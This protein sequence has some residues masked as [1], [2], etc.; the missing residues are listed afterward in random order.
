MLITT[1]A[2][3]G[4]FV[5]CSFFE[6]ALH[7]YIMHDDRL[8][9]YAYQ[10]HQMEHHEIFKADAT[11]FLENA[12]HTDAD[13]KHVT[14]A[15]W[16]APLLFSLHAPLFAGL[17]FFA[18]GWACVVGAFGAMV[19]YYF[20]YEYLHFCMHVPQNRAFERTRFFKFVQNHHRMH[21]V[22]YLRNLNV[23]IPIA[24]FVLRTRVK[25]EDPALYAK[26]ELAR[27]K[28]LARQAAKARPEAA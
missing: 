13:L 16:N 2:F 15:W 11:Y 28:K 21:H 1:L 3:G 23:V 22:Y 24:D 18:G 26:L 6:W 12:P 5:Y 19:F 27:E 14:F 20:L 9:K 17:Y 8:M 25:Q 4:S 7:K 10:A